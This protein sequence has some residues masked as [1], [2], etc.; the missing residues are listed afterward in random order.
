ML[1]WDGII[2]EDEIKNAMAK[3]KNALDHFI[4]QNHPEQAAIAALQAQEDEEPGLQEELQRALEV[5]A[6]EAAARAEQEEQELQ[7][8]QKAIAESQKEAVYK[9]VFTSELLKAVAQKAEEDQVTKALEESRQAEQEEHQRRLAQEEQEENEMKKAIELSLEEERKKQQQIRDY[10]NYQE[11]IRQ[12][13]QQILDCY[14]KTYCSIP[15][16]IN[17]MDNRPIFVRS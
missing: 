11:Q 4:A 10:H 17:D 12:Q 3:H 16:Q 5:S 9:M 13:Q 1:S 6:Q 14:K 7:E 8:L 15:H 2:N